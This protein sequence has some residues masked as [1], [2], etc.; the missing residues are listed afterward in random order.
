M[1]KKILIIDDDEIILFLHQTIVEDLFPTIPSISFK[2][3]KLAYDYMLMN[4]GAEFLLFLDINMPAMNGW[5]LLDLL[6]DLPYRSQLTVIM[7]T[8]SVNNSD[9]LKSYNYPLIKGFLTKPL[10]ISDLEGMSID[11]QFGS[12]FI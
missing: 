6:V 1:E 9:K 7:V 10:R 3:G 8:S 4:A 11:P 2:S 5:Q 12:F